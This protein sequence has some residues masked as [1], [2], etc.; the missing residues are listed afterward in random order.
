MITQL[1]SLDVCL[2]IANKLKHPERVCE[3]VQEALKQGTFI[4]DNWQELTLAEGLPG[5]AMF[6]AMM[7][8]LLPD[9]GW[10]DTAHVYLKLLAEKIEQ[11]DINNSSVFEGITGLCFATYFNSR[12]GTRYQKLLSKLEDLLIKEI[13][14][15]L[16]YQIDYFLDRDQDIPPVFII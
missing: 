12:Q 2:D 8:Q 10:D 9:Q 6:Y 15:S 5:L 1:N 7:D 14:S 4:F 13:E 16:L 3:V 11:Q